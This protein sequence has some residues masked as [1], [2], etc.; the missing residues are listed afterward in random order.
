MHMAG[1]RCTALPATRNR[2]GKMNTWFRP[3]IYAMHG[4]TPGEQPAGQDIVKLNTN[5]N[6]YPPSTA[7]TE[8][9]AKLNAGRLNRYPDPLANPVRDVIA[10]VFGVERDWVLAGKGSDDVLTIVTRAFVDQGGC[11]ATPDPSYSLYP[12]LAEIQGTRVVTVPLDRDFS[13]PPDAARRAGNASLFFI[14]RPN[15][16]TGN[17]FALETMHKVCHEFPGIVVIDEAYADFAADNC[18]DFVRKYP[19]VIVSRT[20]SKGYSLASIRLGFAIGQPNLISGLMKVKDSYNVNYLTQ[21]AAA[22]AIADQDYLRAT[23]ARVKATRERV[24][25]ELA[26][27]GFKV[28]PSQA[29]FLWVKPPKLPAPAYFQGLRQHHVIVRYFKG[30]RTHEYIRITVGT[31]EEM[32]RFLAATRQILG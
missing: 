20:L 3:N 25:E 2:D 16:P 27:L 28:C 19:N 13:L 9:L 10:Q 32:D 30:P 14:A 11:L 1:R 31:D 26:G 15:A 18:L 6:P 4:Y 8:A 17:A 21:I 23:V 24:A 22:A 7:V 29:N 5:E 12:V